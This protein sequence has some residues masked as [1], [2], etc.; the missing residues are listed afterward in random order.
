M[1]AD[2]HSVRLIAARGESLSEQIP[3]TRIPLADSR[4]VRVLQVK[5]QL[6]CGTATRDFE[7]LR[8][9]LVNELQTALSK[10]DVLIAHNVCSLNKNLAL[11]AALY[12]LHSSGRLPTLM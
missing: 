1:T 6:D 9:D 5:A 8:N 11:T 2:G 7:S 4:H 12:Q 10:T 3:L